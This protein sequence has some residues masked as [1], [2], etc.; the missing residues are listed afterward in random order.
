MKRTR[1]AII[2]GRAIGL[3]AL[4]QTLIAG[5]PPQMNMPGYCRTCAGTLDARGACPRCILN[6]AVPKDTGALRGTPFVTPTRADI[7]AAKERGRQAG[8]KGRKR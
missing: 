3:L 6:K 5:A 7:Q 4:T 2:G 1:V 8:R